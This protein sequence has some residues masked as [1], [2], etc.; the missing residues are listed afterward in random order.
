MA[1]NNT[2]QQLQAIQALNG[3]A[4]GAIGLGAIYGLIQLTQGLSSAPKPQTKVYRQAI[5]PKFRAYG[6]CKYGGPLAFFGTDTNINRLFMIVMN[7]Y[8]R[9]NRVISH[10]FNDDALGLVGGTGADYNTDAD[11]VTSPAHYHD[12]GRWCRID[13]K[14]GADDQTSF[15]RLNISGND[16]TERLMPNVWTV[17]HRLRGIAATLIILLCP[18]SDKFSNVFPYGPPEYSQIGE[19]SLVYDPRDTAQNRADKNTWKYTT[20][21][22][23]CF[24]DYL[25][26]P[27]GLALPWEFFSGALDVWRAQADIC[28]RVRQ[29]KNGGSELW[30]QVSGGYALTEQ[31][32]DVIAKFMAAADAWL[33]LRGDGQIV[34]NVADF[35]EPDVTL[36]DDDI[37]DWGGFA[38][39]KDPAE[40]VNIINAKFI[41]PRAGF[42]E[43]QTDPIKNEASAAANG[44]HTKSLDHTFVSTHAQ[45]WFLERIEAVRGDPEWSGEIVTNANGL[46]CLD[47]RNVRINSVR[48][49]FN[50]V[51]EITD[52]PNLDIMTGNCTMTVSAM[53]VATT[54]WNSQTDGGTEPIATWFDD[55]AQPDVPINLKVTVSNRVMTATWDPPLDSGATPQLSYGPYN[56]DSGWT[57]FP[58]INKDGHTASTTTLSA[59][60][61]SVVMSY[62][63][64]RGAYVE[65]IIV[66]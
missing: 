66:S 22:A 18:E 6:K 63:G 40:I 29:L 60:L 34:P 32:K 61:Y 24:L 33:Y 62:G 50:A 43:T 64:S 28:D 23:C 13:T 65:R 54:S 41:N 1:D 57:N 11:V 9:M 59:G 48:H 37:L 3:L 5:P 56:S 21:W 10:Y 45:S 49:G 39:S 36:T 38:R 46:R 4:G 51:F 26:H 20:N 25:T 44:D 35:S 17:D 8:G 12:G 42:E 15:E 27:A 2:T 47:R 19:Y 53:P 52:G 55:A 14:L 16:G 58:T 31:P 30:Y 7:H